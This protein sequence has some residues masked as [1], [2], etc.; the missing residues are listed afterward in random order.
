MPYREPLILPREHKQSP[1]Q[2]I[3][4]RQPWAELILRREKLMEF[5]LWRLPEKYWHR[6][7]WLHVPAAMNGK[8]KETARRIFGSLVLPLGGF[9]GHVRFGHPTWDYTPDEGRSYTGLPRCWCWPVM[10]AERT[11][12]IPARGKLRIFTV[13]ISEESPES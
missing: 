6:W 2:A 5:R 12:F 1:R 4:I 10:G 3:S 7:L 9:V 8:E 11:D 13:E